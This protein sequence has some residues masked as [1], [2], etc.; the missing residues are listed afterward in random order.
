M[1]LVIVGISQTCYAAPIT[2]SDNFNDGN[3]NGWI[4]TSG[5]DR[6]T[7]PSA[8]W[9]VVDGR[10]QGN[11]P[12]D[13]QFAL[14]NNLSLSSQTLQ[15]QTEITH[16]TG[17]ALWY[18][19][20]NNYVSFGSYGSGAAIYVGEWFNGVLFAPVYEHIGPPSVSNIYDWKV[21]TNSS[22]GEIQFFVNGLYEF[23]YTAATTERYGLSGVVSGN[24]G[25][26]FDNFTV[27]SDTCPP[28]PVP[29]PSTMLLLGSGLVG[30]IGYGRKKL[31]S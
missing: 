12:Y 1:A 2:F 4:F 30:L 7:N 20:L 23:T 21:I 17:V 26:Y 31:I 18:K 24:D 6:E 11:S 3:T 25:G 29:E 15:V 10:L 8:H 5:D 14:V 22:T 27:T 9:S 28:A 19:G 16:G 13:A